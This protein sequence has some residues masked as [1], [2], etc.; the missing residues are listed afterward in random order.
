M[1]PVATSEAWGPLCL[2]DATA[3]RTGMGREGQ[4][5]GSLAPT[6]PLTRPRR[7][8]LHVRLFWIS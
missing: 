2:E 4:G 1:N 8:A 6:A 3:Q 5:K 7:A